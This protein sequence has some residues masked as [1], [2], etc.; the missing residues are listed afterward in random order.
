MRK[1]Q[2]IVVNGEDQ[3]SKGQDRLLDICEMAPIYLVAI[4]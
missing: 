2:W 1:A 4:C 3:I